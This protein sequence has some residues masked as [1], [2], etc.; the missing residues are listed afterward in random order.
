MAEALAEKKTWPMASAY[1]TEPHQQ[2]TLTLVHGVPCC[3]TC[4]RQ[5]SDSMSGR[6]LLVKHCIEVRCCFG[7]PGST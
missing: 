2:Q 4:N 5:G 6:L 3:S 1:L 7:V